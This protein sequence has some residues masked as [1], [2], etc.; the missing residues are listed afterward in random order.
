MKKSLLIF[1]LLAIAGLTT[2]SYHWVHRDRVAYW[3]GENSFAAGD[4][5]R[6]IRY[7]APLQEKKGFR[8]KGVAVRLGTAYLALGDDAKALP[9]YEKLVIQEPGNPS[10]VQA[11]AAL[12]ARADRFDEAIGLYRRLLHVRPEDP[13][14][15][16]L[17]ASPAGGGHFEEAVEQYRRALGDEP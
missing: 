6:A 8:E 17:L 10:M 12:Y 4:Y 13:S 9:L 15:R 2:L 3:R 14:V 5:N 11:L 16:I 1:V 7:L